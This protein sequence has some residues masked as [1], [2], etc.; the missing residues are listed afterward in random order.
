MA[1]SK[2]KTGSTPATA[3]A[4][5]AA[6]PEPI[7]TVQAVVDTP[8]PKAAPAPV[9]EKA[10]A[11][12]EP[13]SS[14]AL[15]TL[16]AG[17]GG[18]A[19]SLL[20]VIGV[21]DKAPSQLL[22]PI[23]ALNKSGMFC[24]IAAVPKEIADQMPQGKKDVE[25]VFV[26]YRTEIAAWPAGYD[27]AGEKGNPVY[28]F[29]IS[30]NDVKL[31]KLA[32]EACGNYQFTKKDNK[33]AWDYNASGIG[34]VRPMMAMLVYLPSVDDLIVVQTPSHYSSWKTTVANL[35]KHVDPK[36][37]ALNQMPCLLRPVSTAKNV[38]GFDITENTIEFLSQMNA[39]GKAWWEKYAAFLE[40]LKQDEVR[41][42]ALREWLE[43]GDKPATDEIVERLQKA[44]VF[45]P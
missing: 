33:P 28:S 43:C 27:P 13:A 6:A 42:A 15:S 29:A 7:K 8:A 1:F 11:V 41:L 12:A 20:A 45:K 35:G 14:N 25:A 9:V 44:S 5:V 19:A 23:L 4:P 16:L 21:E 34:H 26:A 40:T 38:N 24:P 30:S 37:G 17:G 39:T 22:F 18:M 31:S 2:L 10:V 3:P 32:T 36:T